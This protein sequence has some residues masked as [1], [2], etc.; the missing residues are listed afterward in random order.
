MSTT[1]TTPRKAG[2]ILGIALAVGSIGALFGDET[3][4]AGVV[5]LG[6]AVSVVVTVLLLWSW[7]GDKAVARRIAVVLLA[8]NAIGAVPGLIVDDVPTYLRIVAGLTVLITIA[9]VVLMF[10]PDRRTTRVARA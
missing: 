8:L 10:Y 2:H 3:P 4:P 1:L 5:V 6:I 7:L 9:A